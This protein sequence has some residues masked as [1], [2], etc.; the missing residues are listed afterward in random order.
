M[1]VLISDKLFSLP[2]LLKIYTV[3]LM[4]MNGDDSRPSTASASFASLQ[5]W[6]F[7]TTRINRTLKFEPFEFRNFP[8]VLLLPK[9]KKP[10]KFATFSLSNG[11]FFPQERSKAKTTCRSGGLSNLLHKDWHSWRYQ[12][13]EGCKLTQVHYSLRFFPWSSWRLWLC[14]LIRHLLQFSSSSVWKLEPLR[15]YAHA[16]ASF[17]KDLQL[18]KVE[19]FTCLFFR[20][21]HPLNLSVDYSWKLRPLHVTLSFGEKKN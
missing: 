7:E 16:F 6:Q 5:H 11:F 15:V 9:R 14:K 18:E 21:V 8:K 4:Q 13:L 17:L 19:T 10:S 12:R 20:N 2:W 3:P 1:V